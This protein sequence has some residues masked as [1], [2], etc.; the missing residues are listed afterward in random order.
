MQH[1]TGLADCMAAIAR[2]AG[3]RSLQAHRFLPRLAS[4]RPDVSPEELEEASRAMGYGAGEQRQGRVLLRC[5]RRRGRWGPC[6]GLLS[7]GCA[8][9]PPRELAIERSCCFRLMIA[10][11]L[12]LSLSPPGCS[13]SQVRGPEEPPHHQLQVQLRRHAEPA[14]G[15]STCYRC[16]CLCRTLFCR[17]TQPPVPPVS[18][19]L[20]RL[21]PTVPLLLFPPT[22]A[23]PLLPLPCSPPSP[24]S[25]GNT[26]VY[27]LYAHARIASIVRK[28]GEIGLFFCFLFSFLSFRFFSSSDHAP[29]AQV[30]EECA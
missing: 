30:G 20:L 15:E 6:C 4:R 26:A 5:C 17:P 10:L 27:Q 8:R 12:S 28:S 21:R 22:L 16:G 14:G 24:T 1:C 2:H 19:P 13:C 18:A 9:C 11:S 3:L 23:S 25:Q 29:R 7:A